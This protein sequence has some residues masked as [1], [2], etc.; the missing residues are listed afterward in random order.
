MQ[1]L[2][3]QGALRVAAAR[4]PEQAAYWAAVLADLPEL[5]RILPDA[6]ATVGPRRQQESLLPAPVSEAARRITRDDAGALRVLLMVAAGAL[7]RRHGRQDELVTAVT[8]TRSTLTRA[9]VVPFTLGRQD[10]LRS[11]LG[12]VSAAV[13]VAEQHADYPIEVLAPTSDPYPFAEVL[14]APVAGSGQQTLDDERFPLVLGIRRAGTDGEDLALCISASPAYSPAVL[15]QILRHLTAVLAAALGSPDNPLW[16]VDLTDAGEAAVVSAAND[17][18]ASFEETARLEDQLRRYAR[19]HPDAVAVET[20]ESHLTYAQLDAASDAIAHRLL[21]AG[22]GR[23]KLVAVLAERGTALITGIFGILKAG[24]AY[25]PIDPGYPAERI[26]YLLEDSAVRVVLTTAAHRE[27]VAGLD[28][29]TVLADEPA[30][31]TQVPAGELPGGLSSSDAA[32]VIYTSGS[33]GR[34]KGVVVEHRSVI[35]RIAWMQKAYP[36]TSDDVLVQK[37]PVSFDVSVWEL[38]WWS[39]AGARLVLP[40]PGVEKDPEALTGVIERHKVSVMHFVPSMLG[41]FVGYAQR[42][43]AADRLASLRQVFASGEALGRHHV[44]AFHHALAREPEKT[45]VLVNLYGPTE[46]TVDVSHHRCEP[47]QAG[48]VPIGVPID[49]LRLYVVDADLRPVPLNVPGELLLAGVGLARGYLGRPELTAERFVRGVLGEEMVYR[50]GDLARW[51][52]QGTVEYLGRLDQQVKVRGHR[53]EPGEIQECLLAVAGVEDAIVLTRPAPD[54]QLVLWAYLTG[55]GVDAE[56]ARAE[57][58]QVLPD[59][60]VPTHVVGLPSLPL[61]PSGKLDR[62][63][64]PTD[65]AATTDYVAPRTEAERSLAGIW[66][67]VLGLERVGI[68]DNLFSLGG[69]SIHFVTVLAHARAL[70]LTFTFQDL[71]RLPTVAGLA[72]AATL[73]QAPPQAPDAHPF[74]LVPDSDRDRLPAGLADAY[75]MTQLQAGLVF[76]TE[77]DK[78]VAGY[79]DILLYTI[80]SSLDIATFEEAVRELVRRTPILRTSYDLTGYSSS[81]Q[82]VHQQAPSPLRLHDLRDLGPQEQEHWYENW[83]EQEKTDR[84]TWDAPGLVRIHV[85]VLADDLFRYGISQHNSALDGWSITL[86]HTDL[87]QIYG[88]LRADRPL[89]EI[90]TGTHLREY[91]VLEQQ[92]LADPDHRDYWGRV[93]DGA[94]LTPVPRSD[95][96]ATDQPF[97]VAFH[98]VDLSDLSTRIKDTADRLQVPVKN[99]LMAGHLAALAALGGSDDVLTGYEHS[100]RPETEGAT[101]AIGLFLNTVPFRVR[102]GQGSWGDLVRAVNAAESALLPARRYPMAQMKADLGV[103]I[104]LFE[105]AFNFTH[106]SLLRS[107]DEHG[108]SLLD[109]RANSETEFVL[110]AEFSQHFRTDEIRLSLHHHLTVIDSQLALMFARAY[111]AAFTAITARTDE[112]QDVRHLLPGP[113]HDLLTRLRPE[114]V[115]FTPAQARAHA[116]TAQQHRAPVTSTQ[117]RIAEA[118]KE[119]LGEGETA[120]GLD[121]NFFLRGGTSLSAMRLAV[122]LAGLVSIADIMRNSRLEDLSRVA[123]KKVTASLSTS[124]PAAT[125]GPLLHLVAGDPVRAGVTLICFPYAGGGATIFDAFGQA[126]HRQDPRVAVYSVALP[127][128]DISENASA[129]KSLEQIADALVTEIEETIPTPV[130]LWGHCVGSALAL[131]T[132][133]L[134]EKDSDGVRHLFIGAKLLYPASSARAGIAEARAMSDQD[135]VRW[136]GEETGLMAALTAGPQVGAYLARVFRHDSIAANS[137]LADVAEGHGPHLETPLTLVLAD[138]DPLTANGPDVSAWAVTGSDP[139]VLTIPTGGHYFCESEP[140]AAAALVLERLHD[141]EL[142]K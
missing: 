48:P 80:S 112:P 88:D 91:A 126:L 102:L 74:A 5:S 85:H 62:A 49:N 41:A 16:D 133:H 70:G 6:S 51:S 104:P 95:R 116:A 7:L 124:T 115:P 76:E 86:L 67:Q 54:G 1:S 121:D 47:G 24:A 139:Q 46:A 28:V 53:I 93:L 90:T 21:A 55:E 89:P 60:M 31:G 27:V 75:P 140:D 68:D 125:S 36:L 2:E 19:S 25:V 43:G 33:T 26:A 9:L 50:S 129:L 4:R 10:T 72:S 101:R 137:Y 100:G 108:F 82:L 38:F 114:P 120:I 77:L 122:E 17:T 22:A 110:R 130:A 37:T 109:V 59:Y 30:A 132:A 45:C 12:R 44:D 71:F 15:T 141:Q 18:R 138:D 58:A 63:A 98:E 94:T 136:L 14:I 97:E 131:R 3:T 29:A 99:V 69:N 142:T 128:H 118:W 83:V 106:F 127:G 61:T 81:L 111:Q 134:L 84:F 73:G 117:M 56:R 52:P 42:T 23:E 64:L 39:F 8:P 79:H 113:D 123:E 119:V 35:N 66:A 57:V 135:V 20:G 40:Q 32:Y 92:S 96:H 107:L 105:T 78:S 11:A 65:I 103:Q 87:F 13:A 34:P